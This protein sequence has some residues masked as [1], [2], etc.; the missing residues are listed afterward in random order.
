MEYEEENLRARSNK[1]SHAYDLRTRAFALCTTRD[2]SF[3]AGIVAR[4][5]SS[6]IHNI[7][8]RCFMVISPASCCSPASLLYPLLHYYTIPFFLIY[9]LLHYYIPYLI[10]NSPTLSSYP[11]SIITTPL[12]YYIPCFIITSLLRYKVLLRMLKQ[13]IDLTWNFLSSILLITIILP[14]TSSLCLMH[15]CTTGSPTSLFAPQ[16]LARLAGKKYFQT[17]TT[18]CDMRSMQWCIK[19]ILFHNLSM[20]SLKSMQ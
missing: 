19:L 11:F 4:N 20:Y 1:V 12:Y 15:P 17:L 14:P 5:H 2:L 13:L 18:S 9:P 8:R 10:I 3:N 7:N 6:F 16:H